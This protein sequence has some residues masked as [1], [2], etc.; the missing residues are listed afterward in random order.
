MLKLWPC[1]ITEANKIVGQWHR[2]NRPTQGGLFAVAVKEHDLIVGVAIVGRP[3]ARKSQDGVTCEI[4]RV[5]TNGTYNAC[6]MLYGSCCRA[7]KALGYTRVV[8]KTLASEPGTSLKASGFTDLGLTP[9]SS[10]WQSK[11]RDR[12]DHD[13]FGNELRPTGAKRRWQRDFI[14]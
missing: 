10:S 5:A 9:E 2:H 12:F 14:H 6:S 8:T 11:S 13:L 3:I 1:T 4:L 7:A